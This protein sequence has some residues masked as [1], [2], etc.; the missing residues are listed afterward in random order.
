MHKQIHDR[1][2]DHRPVTGHQFTHEILQDELSINFKPLNYEYDG[3]MDP[4]EHVIRFENSTIL[5]RY[6]EGG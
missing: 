6:G 5:H 2:S 3:T 4:Y 1:V